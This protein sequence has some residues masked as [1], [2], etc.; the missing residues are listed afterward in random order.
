M[1]S[2]L[3]I[4]DKSISYKIIGKEFHSDV[5]IVFLHDA[6][7][8]ISQWGSFPQRVSSVLGMPVLVYERFGHGSSDKAEDAKNKNFF[9]NE[10]DILSEFLEKLNIVKNVILLGSSDGGTISL[11][12]LSQYP[13]KVIAAVTIAAHTFVE[14]ITVQGVLNTKPNSGKLIAALKKYQPD[15]AE[16]LYFGWYNLWTSSDIKDWNMFDDLKLIKCPVLAIQGDKDEYGTVEQLNAIKTN[17][18]SI[19][20][21][22]LIKNAGHFPHFEKENEVIELIKKFISDVLS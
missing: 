5:I 7:G 14:D 3:K 12:F 22:T 11:S 21:T 17:V 20:K 4:R 15:Y 13:E 19:C 10:A 6:L 18:K 1:N 8:S 16:S 9:K 2:F